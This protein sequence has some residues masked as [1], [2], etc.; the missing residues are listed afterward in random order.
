MEKATYSVPAGHFK[1]KC[2]QLMDDEEPVDFF[3]CL[4][5]TVTIKKNIIQPIDIVWEAAIKA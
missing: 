5:D 2:L 3:G 1:S 4:K